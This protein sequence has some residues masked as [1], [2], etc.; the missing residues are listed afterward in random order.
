MNFIIE[1]EFNFKRP[2]PE[3]HIEQRFV[4]YFV[5]CNDDVLCVLCYTNK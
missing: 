3:P 1:F 4:L 2:F 5:H